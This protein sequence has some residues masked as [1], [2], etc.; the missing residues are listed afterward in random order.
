MTSGSDFY[1]DEAVFDTYTKRR[2]HTDNPNDTIEKP[3]FMEMLGDVRDRVILDLGCG[4]GAFGIELLAAGCRSYTGIEASVRMIAASEPLR[5]A[6]GRIHQIP[7]EDWTYPQ[8]AFDVVVS[9]LVL[10]YVA[11][12]SRTFEQIYQTLKPGG[13]LVFSVEHPVLTSC[14]RSATES[15]I[16][17]DWIVDDYFVTGARNVSW[18]HS[19]VVK[20]HR[21]IDNYFNGLQQAQF[22]V[23][24][25]RESHPRREMFTDEA[26][27]TRRTRIPLFLM[28]AARRSD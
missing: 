24:Q 27:Y 16:R 6:G 3:I 5:A 1:D 8:Q 11:D 28:L 15:G 7:I 14:N 21:T 4:D 18:M 2:Q 26:L 22:T 13:R 23:E 9:R 12:I 20:Y 25:L 17:Y 10:H 19:Q